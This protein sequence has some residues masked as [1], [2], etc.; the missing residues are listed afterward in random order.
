M[1]RICTICA[2][3]GS[4]GVKDKNI[5]DLLGHPLVAHS[6]MQAKA[7]LLFDCIAISSDSAKI[8]QIGKDYGSDLQIIR[9]DEL[10]S[11]AA[12]KIPAI[13]HC[14]LVAEQLNDLKYDTVVDLDATSPLRLPLDIVE[15]VAMLEKTGVSSVITA[16][17]ARRSPY[18][19]LLELS[20]KGSVVLS[21][22][23]PSAIH[24]RQN[25]PQCFDQNASIY[26]WARQALMDNPTDIFPDT[27]L[28][29]MPEERSIDIDSEL[30]FEFV[31]FIAKKRGCLI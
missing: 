22:P 11:D 24:C 5:R 10:S 30:D 12:P 29:V 20:D 6:I 21:K 27:K 26:A 19:N 3:A 28:Y 23:P 18:F 17:P 1:K 14:V 2:R 7:T 8:L 15:V 9:P 31:E 25:S 13:Q 16:M 4:K